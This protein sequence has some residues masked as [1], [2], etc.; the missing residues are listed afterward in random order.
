MTSPRNLPPAL[1]FRPEA[2]SLQDRFGASDLFYREIGGVSARQDK[3]GD[4]RHHDCDDK[5]DCDFAK[6][7]HVTRDNARP[8]MRQPISAGAMRRKATDRDV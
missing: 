2:L 3:Q 5:S 7:S 6:K 4:P 1:R 8:P